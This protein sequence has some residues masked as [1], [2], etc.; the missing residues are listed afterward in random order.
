MR[1][2]TLNA[3]GWRALLLVS[4]SVIY[5]LDGDRKQQVFTDVF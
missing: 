3:C 2:K 4:T 1:A 5:W